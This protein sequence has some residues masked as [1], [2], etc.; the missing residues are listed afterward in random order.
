MEWRVCC[1]NLIAQGTSFIDSSLKLQEHP[2]LNSIPYGVWK[3]VFQYQISSEAL[4]LVEKNIDD[5]LSAIA[6][7]SS[8]KLQ[9]KRLLLMYFCNKEADRET[10]MNGLKKNRYRP[11]NI[12]SS[13]L[14]SG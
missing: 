10:F 13:R 2:V 7:S 3:D 8:K 6:Q 11:V 1:K 5:A 4:L 9:L 12:N 14:H